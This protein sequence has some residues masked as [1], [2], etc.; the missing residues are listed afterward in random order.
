MNGLFDFLHQE[1]EQEPPQPIILFNQDGAYQAG[2]LNQKNIG[3]TINPEINNVLLPFKD[4]TKHEID[5][6]MM[7]LLAYSQKEQLQNPRNPLAETGIFTISAHAKILV[8]NTS[9]GTKK[10]QE[11]RSENTIYEVWIKRYLAAN[12]KLPTEEEKRNFRTYVDQN[13][14]V[15]SQVDHGVCG[16]FGGS[17]GPDSF[18]SRQ[19]EQMTIN[20]FMQALVENEEI[21]MTPNVI[22]LAI[23]FVRRELRATFTDDYKSVADMNS[24]FD[25][26]KYWHIQIQDIAT[27]KTSWQSYTEMNADFSCKFFECMPNPNEGDTN[28]NYG[29]FASLIVNEVPDSIYK[30]NMMMEPDKYIRMILDRNNYPSRYKYNK[31]GSD[32]NP[33]IKVAIEA[34]K[35][36][37]DTNKI[38]YAGIIAIAMALKLENLIFF[39]SGCQ[40]YQ[41]LAK[42]GVT[43]RSGL[44]LSTPEQKEAAENLPDTF[45]SSLPVPDSPFPRGGKRRNKMARRTR[46]KSGRRI[47]RRRKR[48]NSNNRRRTRRHRTR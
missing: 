44:D 7:S 18:S 14:M 17:D 16:V 11:Y 19:I 43:T 1:Q 35:T 31:K 6:I 10:I 34:I 24:A 39:D 28:A 27:K 8:E 21:V 36:L 32:I 46:K 20:L 47:S 25:P 12:L 13:F 38:D 48:T 5:I 29:M 37:S 30:G 9:L 33:T 22:Q 4:I 40:Y 41:D 42:L 2:V 3:E 45:L 23:F 26:L 15:I